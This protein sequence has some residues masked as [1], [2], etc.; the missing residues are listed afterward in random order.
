[1][2]HARGLTRTYAS[3]AGPFHALRGVDLDVAPGEFVAVRGPS[4]SGKTTL[5]NLLCGIDRPTA[6]EVTVA[7][8]ALAS[9]PL[10]RLAPFR[11]RALGIVF[12]FFQLLPTLTVLENVLLPMELRGALAGKERERRARALLERFDVLAHADKLPAGLSGGQQQ[13]VAVARALA[14]DPPIL[15]AD[16][17][18]GNL[19]R[20]NG[21]GVLAALRALAHEGKAVLVVTHE[22]DAGAA[23]DRAIV[24]R[25]GRVVA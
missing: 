5:L 18:T 4:G 1:M 9:L 15:L 24:L 23:F 10:S 7:G 6:G 3:P 22:Q 2:I 21:A 11:G 8:E 19:D 20:D 17:P 25:D 12:Q 13:R 16:E 14:N